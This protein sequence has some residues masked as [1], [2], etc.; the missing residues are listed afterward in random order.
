MNPMSAFA[1]YERVRNRLPTAAFPGNSQV[2]ANLGELIEAF[3]AFVFD[4]FGVLNIGETPIGGAR[5]RI[6][7]LRSAGKQVLVLT[8]AATGPLSGLPAKYRSLGFDFEAS[9]IVSSREI[10]ANALRTRTDQLN[11]GVHDGVHSGI[12]CGI[13]W[14]VVA[15]AAARIEELPG[16]V[17][18]LPDSNADFDSPDGFVLLSSQ[19]VDEQTHSR[20]ADS[21]ADRNRPLLVGN[22]DLVAPREDGFS[23][24]PGFYAHDLADRLAIA[25][26]FFGKPFANAFEETLSRLEPG[27]D[28]QRVAMIGDTLH[29]DILG[30]AAAGFRTVLVTA[31]GVMKEMDVAA[32][33]ERSGI[34]PDFIMPAI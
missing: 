17:T 7:R 15:P 32:C 33:I 19:A 25:P 21:L 9:E 27:I 30:G 14:G 26:A 31:H 18:L 23:L 16:T 4:S 6:A 34:V 11:S 5:E 24:E 10:L 28:P 3:D 20:L 2:R 22:P 13:H 1:R 8:N 12:H 29:T